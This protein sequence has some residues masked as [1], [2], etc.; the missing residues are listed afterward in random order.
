MHLSDA[1]IRNLK[2]PATGQ[3]AYYDDAIPGFSVRVS[4]GA[5]T[6]SLVY[7]SPR[8][9]I[10]LGRYPLISLSQ[11]RE[12]ARKLLAHRMLHGD[13]PP[14]I[15]LEEA[16]QLFLKLHCAEHN[17]PSSARETE[18]L[19][20]RHW[21]PKL[22]KRT[23]KDISTAHILRITD[24]LARTPTER[25]HAHAAMRGLLR[26]ATRR[27]YVPHSVMEG[28]TMPA[29]ETPR[30]RTLSPAELRI[31]FSHGAKS[32]V[33]GQIIQLLILTGQRKGQFQ[34]LKR[35]WIGEDT[36]H[37]PAAHMK[38]NREHLLPIGPLT[39]TI[40]QTFPIPM[41]FNN[42]A[43]S[44][45][46]FLKATGLSHFRRH[47]LRRTYATI[48]AQWTP[49]HVLDRLLAHTRGQISGV[50]A[51]Y[52]RHAYLTEM[53]EAVLNFERWLTSL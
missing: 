10:T 11:A 37:W 24:S 32:G 12:K 2:T 26:W 15:T 13:T 27:R 18:R 17:R 4:Q 47:D 43:R 35:E 52:N 53:R 19:L 34:H 16:A 25:N 29:R 44:H 33:Y 51:I 6:F 50:A 30:S 40:L 3:K 46:A 23:L 21:L 41:T 8:K 45:N 39:Q 36:I 14:D 49:P 5:K 7:G 28:L 31:A 22:G 48:M 42:W 1:T 9:R 20:R 38:S